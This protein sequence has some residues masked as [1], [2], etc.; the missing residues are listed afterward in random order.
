M[1]QLL[2]TLR[3]TA[4]L[5]VLLLGVLQS[6]QAV[7]RHEH[8]HP[9]GLHAGDCLLCCLPGLHNALTAHLALAL[10]PKQ[11]FAPFALHCQRVPT[12]PSVRAQARAPPAC[13]Q[14]RHDLLIV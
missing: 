2:P 14:T 12:Q 11:G 4:L 8:D 9:A 13:P 1:L 3:R 7:E 5:A 6:V 10:P